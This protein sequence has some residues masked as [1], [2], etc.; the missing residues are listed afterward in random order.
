M[1]NATAAELDYYFTDPE[2]S[3]FNRK[4]VK[5]VNIIRVKGPKPIEKA[6]DLNLEDST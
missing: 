2:T 4:L 5:K 6:E 3:I 1:N